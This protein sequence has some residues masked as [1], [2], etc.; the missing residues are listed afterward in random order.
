M[1]N[2]LISYACVKKLHKN[3][4]EQGSESFRVSGHVEVREDFVPQRAW[5]PHPVQL[6]VLGLCTSRMSP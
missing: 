2:D 1:A 3:L 6:A 4:E 5:N